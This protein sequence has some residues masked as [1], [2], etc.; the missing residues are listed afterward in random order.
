MFYAW[1]EEDLKAANREIEQLKQRIEHFS[2]ENEQLRSQLD[3]SQLKIKDLE[4][5]LLAA[6]EM[7]GEEGEEGQSNKKRKISID[8]EAIFEG[9]QEISIEKSPHLKEGALEWLTRI[10]PSL[11]TKIYGI[12]E[13]IERRLEIKSCGSQGM[14]KTLS[15]K[16]STEEMITWINNC[17]FMRREWSDKKT[18][19]SSTI[20]M[21]AF[22][23]F[24]K[25]EGLLEY[26]QWVITDEKDLRGLFASFKDLDLAVRRCYYVNEV[27]TRAE[28]NAERVHTLNKVRDV[29]GL[30]NYK[31]EKREELKWTPGRISTEQMEI[32]LG[33][34]ERVVPKVVKKDEKNPEKKK[35]KKIVMRPQKYKN[36]AFT[37]SYLADVW[38][39]SKIGILKFNF[40][41]YC[42]KDG[43]PDGN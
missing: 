11:I 14:G 18:K 15:I 24:P 30:S 13:L 10:A 43:V 17:P 23:G 8:K 36:A 34:I 22:K 28:V 5:K 41:Y 1:E 7:L 2:R 31:Q 3:Q 26:R 12:M 33:H 37:I 4:Q 29:E 21:K 16:V 39:K 25:P 6:K 32:Q 20:K 42:Y 27:G 9:L 40:T 19:E 38:P 35:P